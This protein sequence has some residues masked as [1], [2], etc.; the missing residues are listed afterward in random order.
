MLT[1]LVTS[2]HKLL[3]IHF[4]FTSII[5]LTLDVP[6]ITSCTIGVTSPKV[7]KKAFAIVA[8]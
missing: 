8:I 7:A 4:S 1:L 5:F 2:F 6:H 3:P